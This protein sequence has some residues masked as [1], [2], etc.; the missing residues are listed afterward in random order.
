MVLVLYALYFASDSQLS[1]LARLIPIDLIRNPGFYL[2]IP[3][4]LIRLLRFSCSSLVT[5]FP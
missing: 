5:L 1:Y 3:I 4:T 2:S